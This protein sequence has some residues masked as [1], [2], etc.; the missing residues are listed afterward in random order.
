MDPLAFRVA[1]AWALAFGGAILAS[2]F[3]LGRGA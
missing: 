3:V 1:D 2:T